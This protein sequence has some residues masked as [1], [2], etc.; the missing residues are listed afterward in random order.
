MVPRRVFSLENTLKL[1][2]S[3]QGMASLGIFGNLRSLAS[4][5]MCFLCEEC[6]NFRCD[7]DMGIQATRVQIR[8]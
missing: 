3:E 2:L 1:Y 5:Q 8:G 4:L 7:M 6:M